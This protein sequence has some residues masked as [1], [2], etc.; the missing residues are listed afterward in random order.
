MTRR[1]N[2][3]VHWLHRIFSGTMRVERNQKSKEV[4]K[5][6][7]MGGEHFGKIY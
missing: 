2:S 5:G 3:L 1:G 7:F 6:E 4:V